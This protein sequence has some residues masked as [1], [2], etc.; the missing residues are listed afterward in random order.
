MQSLQARITLRRSGE[1]S[2]W[3]PSRT[4]VNSSCILYLRI[5]L[6][7]QLDILAMKGNYQDGVGRTE[8]EGAK[9]A[10]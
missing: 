8:V 10:E 3:K 1:D 6:L 5:A 9:F 7:F 4:F 2:H